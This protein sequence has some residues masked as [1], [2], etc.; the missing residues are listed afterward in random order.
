[1]AGP[2]YTFIDGINELVETV[3]EFPMSGGTKPSAGGDTAS[4]YYLA[5]KH[6]D[7]HNKRVQSQGWPENTVYSKSYTPTTVNSVAN[8]VV[9]AETV[10]KIQAASTSEGRPLVLRV[11]T[12]DSDTPKVFDA[13][14]NS[15]NL[16]STDAVFL[17]QVELLAFEDLTPE[18]QDVILTQAK[19]SFQRMFQGNLNLDAVLS[20]E[21]VKAN[22]MAARNTFDTRR[23]FNAMPPQ[24]QTPRRSSEQ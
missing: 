15:F 17:D 6:I 12:A 8:V 9:L 21:E 18:L 14:L 2:G 23:A 10:L 19:A 5:E 20:T 11:D 7:R 1:M 4:I 24:P 3:G 13:I 16:G 22:A